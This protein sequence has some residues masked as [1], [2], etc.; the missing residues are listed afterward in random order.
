MK[1]EGTPPN[2]DRPL[3]V[4]LILAGIVI[5]ILF[6]LSYTGPPSAVVP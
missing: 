3:A 5:V 2:W 1:K 6:I 4:L